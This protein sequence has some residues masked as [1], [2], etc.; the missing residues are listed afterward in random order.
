MERPAEPVA[1]GNCHCAR[2]RGSARP[3]SAGSQGRKRLTRIAGPMP[4]LLVLLSLPFQSLPIKFRAIQ[5][6]HGVAFAASPRLP[7]AVTPVC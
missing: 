4:F 5:E 2:V 6:K 1:D 3:F 7:M